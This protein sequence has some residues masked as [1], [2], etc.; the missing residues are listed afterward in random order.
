MGKP[1]VL[2]SA[3]TTT[4]T[5]DSKQ[6]Y[7]ARENQVSAVNARI[8]GTGTVSATIIMER[9]PEGDGVN[10]YYGFTIALSGTN[11]DNFSGFITSTNN[12]SFWRS[13]ITAISGT[14]ATVYV[15][16]EP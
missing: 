8:S 16:V 11:S 6:V 15:E 7:P 5:S 10:W 12:N 2:L 14:G 1:F 3:A 13:R 9:S 4:A